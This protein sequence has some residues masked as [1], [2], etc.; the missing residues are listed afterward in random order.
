[1]I[2]PKFLNLGDSAL[3]LEFGDAIDQRLV[4][5]V[6]A[7]DTRVNRDIETG[8]L[9]GVVETIPTFRSLTVIFNPLAL[10]RKNADRLPG[11]RA[12]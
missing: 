9:V 12:G 11:G 10:P 3:T 2:Q 6:V 1:M 8:H 7:L 4:A 5:A